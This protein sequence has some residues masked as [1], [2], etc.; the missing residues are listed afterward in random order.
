MNHKL[1][2]NNLNLT[3]CYQRELDFWDNQ[4]KTRNENIL[5]R[6][7]Q[8]INYN[9][10]QFIIDIIDKIKCKK[11]NMPKVMDFGCGPVSNLCYLHK[12]KL[13][14][15]IGVDVLS[16]KY[17]D[18]YKRYNLDQP[19]PL[20]AC[21][22]ENLMDLFKESSFDLVYTQNALDHTICPTLT[23]L[24]LCK[25]TKL[26]GY[27]GHAHAIN[28]ADH[29]KRDHLHQFNL[30]PE[31]SNFILD[32]LN[33]NIINLNSIMGLNMVYETII[34]IKENYSYFVQIWE[35]T[36]ENIPKEFLLDTINN[37]LKSF[38]KRSDWCHVLEKEIS[39]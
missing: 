23:W 37:L 15:L 14:D 21:S 16:S 25:L 5:K 7:D 9:C 24:N 26:G 18:L 22:G 39:I 27:I 2:K 35:K 10:P 4:I 28:E 6:F 34:P 30:R 20:V 12:E 11:I 36:D 8:T 38:N 3:F 31:N 33:G 17:V 32:D 29:E 19:I 1:S 13:A